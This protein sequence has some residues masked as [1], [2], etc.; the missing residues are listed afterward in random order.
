MEQKFD[1]L[2]IKET[3]VVAYKD[4]INKLKEVEMKLGKEIDK[5]D[6]SA[7]HKIISEFFKNAGAKEY[8]DGGSGEINLQKELQQIARENPSLIIRRQKPELLI[9]TIT[10]KTPLEISFDPEKHAG[11]PYPN[12]AILGSDLS[13]L[14]TPYTQGFG[15]FDKGAG[16]L[17]FIAGIKQGDKLNSTALSAG[18]FGHYNGEKRSKIRKVY[19]S[20]P[21][22]DIKFIIYRIPKKLFPESEMTDWELEHPEILH[23]KRLY[24]LN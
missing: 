14:I 2:K 11:K 5:A 23:I 8:L 9:K 13:G 6:I 18:E 3:K 7:L 1:N 22:E 20:V 4:V 19:G 17:V 21:Y 24:E 12:A 15:N 10:E 16:A